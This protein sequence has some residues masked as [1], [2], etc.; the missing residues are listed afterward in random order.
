[1]SS[2]DGS[3]TARFRVAL[4]AAA[5]A[6][7]YAATVATLVGAG[8]FI[9]GIATGGGFVRVKSTLF[10]AGIGMMAYATARLWP[11][12]PSD[13]EPDGFDGVTAAAGSIPAVPDQTRFQRFVMSLPPS[14]WLPPAPPTKRVTPAG[15]M[16]LGSV[17]VLLASYLMEARFGVV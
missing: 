10:L 2:A 9:F 13:L 4:L 6:T 11:R 15:K 5:H 3:V 12:S 14:R 16:F 8:A 1:M 17:F 7:T